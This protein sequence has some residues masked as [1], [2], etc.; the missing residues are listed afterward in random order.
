MKKTIIA[1][2]VMLLLALSLGAQETKD[3]G[4]KYGNTL[5]IGLGAGYYGYIGRTV[6]MLHMDYE[7]DIARNITIAPSISYLAYQN[8]YYW[9]NPKYPYRNY[10]YRQTVVPVGVKAC[11]YFD[12]MLKAGAAWDF[13]LALSGGVTLQKTSWETGYYGETSVVRQSGGVFVDFHIGMEYHLGKKAGL[14]LDLSTGNST[15]GL[16]IHI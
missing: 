9:G 13:Y 2:T 5:N 3:P 12:K 15:F 1:C 11:Y 6:P 4:E 7:I 8:Y 16:A 10:S 14:F